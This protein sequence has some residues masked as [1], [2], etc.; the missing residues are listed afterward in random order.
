MTRIKNVP[1]RAAGPDIRHVVIGNEGALCFITEVTVKLFRYQPEN[2]RS[3]ASCVDDFATGGRG[4]CARSSSA[5]TAPRSLASTPS[6]TPASTSR[7]SPTA[8]S[9]WSS[10][11]RARSRSPRDRDG[12]RGVV[13]RY[14]HDRVDP[15][16]IEE[17]FEGPQ[18]GPGQDRR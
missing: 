4:R 14:P 8:R 12:D 17:W 16:L 3:S 18:L 6:R 1:R 7:T 2:N 9:S 10:S 11:P 5:A 15:A 13:G